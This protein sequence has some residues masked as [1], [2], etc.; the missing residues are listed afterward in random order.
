MFITSAL[1]PVA[2]LWAGWELF[3]LT[4]GLIASTM[5]SLY[6]VL[7]FYAGFYLTESPLALGLLICLGA[8]GRCLRM[9]NAWLAT[10]LALLTGGFMGILASWKSITLLTAACTGLG[11]AVL[12]W[13][14]RV[15]R[16][17]PVGVAMVIGT[18]AGVAPFAVRC[19]KLL[20][21]EPCLIGT[22]AS[23]N[24]LM[25]HYGNVRRFW[26]QD[27]KRRLTLR[28]GCPISAAKKFKHEEKLEIGAWETKKLRALAWSW[29]KKHP[30]DAAYLSVE[31]V[32]DTFFFPIFW[33]LSKWKWRRYLSL[34]NNLFWFL[35]L[36]PMA[37]LLWQ[38]RRGIVR[39]RASE[40]GVL[41][42]LLCVVALCLAMMIAKGEPRY[43]VP[44][45][46]IMILMAS[47][48]YA[49]RLKRERAPPPMPDDPPPAD[50]SHETRYVL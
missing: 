17:I 38:R 31:H 25:G 15:K 16:L 32:F 19:T 24:F 7:V 45:D 8:L 49:E 14:Y 11:L 20:E 4:V 46:P 39:F 3:G 26:F 48:F 2:A 44:F 5:T 13:K 30:F 33:P 41:V 47:V 29:I 34:H 28:F 37:I 9:R 18:M 6:F 42:C 12:C 50:P 22:E 36:F 27:K 21:G 35:V 1:V 10:G 40:S 43:R 23:L